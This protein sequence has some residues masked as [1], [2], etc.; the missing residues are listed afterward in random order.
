MVGGGEIEQTGERIHGH[1]QHCGDCGWGGG[2]RGLNGNER[3]TIKYFV[4]KNVLLLF[5][6]CNN[7][8]SC[9][10]LKNNSP[11]MTQGD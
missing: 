2:L 8:K 6:E 1:E 3:N 11:E 10:L 5:L 7:N 9:L 4:A